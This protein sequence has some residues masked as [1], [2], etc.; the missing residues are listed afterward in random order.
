MGFIGHIDLP[1]REQRAQ[2]KREMSARDFV[3]LAALGSAA[4]GPVGL[5]DICC[6]IDAITAG[7]WLPV[8][9]LVT[10]AIA[11]MVRGD[12]LRI[13]ADQD[14]W[15]ELTA[16]G[17]D[18]LSRLLS[19]PTASPSSLLGQVGIALK[20]AFLD[21]MDGGEIRAHLDALIRL[22][23]DDLSRRAAPGGRSPASGRFGQSWRSHEIDRLRRG[24]A[25]LRQMATG[26]EDLPPL[27]H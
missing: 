21:V 20:L 13:A 14:G 12:H 11:E 9:D 5:D 26:L 17:R 27:R 10:T 15:L 8:P 3:W 18:T 22:Y 19:C 1:S 23:E 2:E 24:L 6:A 16:R 4:R 25:L 7:Q